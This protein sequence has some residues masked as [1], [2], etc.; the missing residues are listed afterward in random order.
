M[1]QRMTIASLQD[2]LVA[3][4]QTC[5]VLRAQL[6][7]TVSRE[8]CTSVGREA[9]TSVSREACTSVKDVTAL[10]LRPPAPLAAPLPVVSNTSNSTLTSVSSVVC[11]SIQTSK[12]NLL[13]LQNGIRSD[14]GII[15]EDERES[16]LRNGN[17]AVD[18][19]KHSD[20]NTSVEVASLADVE[21]SNGVLNKSAPENRD[22]SSEDSLKD[23]VQTKALTTSKGNQASSLNTNVNNNFSS[24]LEGLNRED[25]L[26]CKTSIKDSVTTSKSNVVKSSNP[27][28]SSVSTATKIKAVQKGSSDSKKA[29]PKIQKDKDGSDSPITTQPQPVAVPISTDDAIELGRSEISSRSVCESQFLPTIA[30]SRYFGPNPLTNPSNSVASAVETNSGYLYVANGSNR[31]GVSVN[32]NSSSNG[33]ASSECDK[34]NVSVT[35]SNVRSDVLYSTGSLNKDAAPMFRLNSNESLGIIN[36]N[37]FPYHAPLLDYPA[38]SPVYSNNIAVDANNDNSTQTNSKSSQNEAGSSNGIVSGDYSSMSEFYSAESLPPHLNGIPGYSP[39]PGVG[40]PPGMYPPTPGYPYSIPDFSLPV[41]NRHA[42]EYAS[43]GVLPSDVLHPS[44]WRSPE[45]FLQPRF[46]RRPRDY[47]IPCRKPDP[48]QGEIHDI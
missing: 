28:V 45:G 5:D 14:T 12:S 48:K 27:V 24:E 46:F 20:S 38:M 8:A 13:S 35:N 23:N 40:L 26:N 32:N 11:N 41:Q 2:A 17:E 34:N 15:K 19:L 43:N 25:D 4:K 31:I 37:V 3:S 22:G 39:V 29:K 16:I 7:Q 18:S 36:N 21:L 6:D 47:V 44:L 10:G 1:Q 9:C 42:G 30:Q 33:V